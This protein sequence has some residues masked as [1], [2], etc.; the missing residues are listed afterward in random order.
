[1]AE[2]IDEEPVDEVDE[3]DREPIDEMAPERGFKLFTV[4]SC[5][6]F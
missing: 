2:L 1:M 6:K 5:S 3:D 4:R